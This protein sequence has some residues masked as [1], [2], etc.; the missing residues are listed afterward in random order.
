MKA[1]LVGLFGAQLGDLRLAVP[2]PAFGPI[3]P[4]GAAEPLAQDLERGKPYE[5][6]A[7]LVLKVFEVAP[8]RIGGVAKARSAAIL[9]RATPAYCTMSA[10]RSAETCASSPSAARPGNSPTALRSM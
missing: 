1:D 5:V 9:A 4:R 10:A 7:L 3:P 8:A 2:L 6:L